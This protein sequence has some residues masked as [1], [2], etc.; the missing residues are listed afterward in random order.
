MILLASAVMGAVLWYGSLWAAPALGRG[1][2]LWLRIGSLAAL[3]VTGAL[4]YFSALFAT[5]VLSL[6]MLRSAFRRRD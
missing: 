4:V 1:E 6:S 5:R 2:P 3:M